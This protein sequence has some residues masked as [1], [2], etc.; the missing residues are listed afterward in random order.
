MMTNKERIQMYQ[1]LVKLQDIQIKHLKKELSIYRDK[2][3]RLLK[4]LDY[5]NRKNRNKN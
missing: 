2:Y 5:E 3:S 4:E 1:T